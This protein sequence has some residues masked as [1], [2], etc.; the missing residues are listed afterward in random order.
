MKALSPNIHEN[1]AEIWDAVIPKLVQ[2]LHGQCPVRKPLIICEKETAIPSVLLLKVY[3]WMNLHQQFTASCWIA[4]EM[5]LGFTVFRCRWRWRQVVTEILGGPCIKSTSCLFH[6]TKRGHWSTLPLFC[7]M[8][9]LLSDVVQKSGR[10]WQ[11]RLDFWIGRSTWSANPT[12]Q[13]LSWGKG[14]CLHFEC[15]VWTQKKTWD[16]SSMKNWWNISWAKWT[17]HQKNLSAAV[18]LC[19]ETCA[20]QMFSETDSCKRWYNKHTQSS[21]TEYCVVE[22]PVQMSGSHHE[23]VGEERFRGEAPGPRVQHRETHE[24]AGEGGSFATDGSP[25]ETTFEFPVGPFTPHA[26]C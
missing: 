18:V 13:L 1:L 21:L 11:R 16:D 17:E 5:F 6:S 20:S 24:P 25:C 7:H 23:E 9:C 26:N 15:W 2:F 10:S 3:I 8:I 22:F 19:D 4:T 12:V 14:L